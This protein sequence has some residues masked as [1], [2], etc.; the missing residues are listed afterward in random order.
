MALQLASAI[1]PSAATSRF[2]NL[3]Y[4]RRPALHRR[5]VD[6]RL[7]AGAISTRSVDRRDRLDRR[8]RHVWRAAVR[9]AVAQL[10]WID[11]LSPATED[12]VPL[13]PWFGVV[14]VVDQYLSLV[15]IA[16]EY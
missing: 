3:H 7:A 6:P 9:F 14:L 13:L 1:C 8:W 15:E 11:D 12:Y 2:R 16:L 10:G 5:L 4:L